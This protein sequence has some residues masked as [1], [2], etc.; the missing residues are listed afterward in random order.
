MKIL[1]LI[2]INILISVILFRCI[3]WP[4]Y[5]FGLS[6]IEL[7]VYYAIIFIS[8]LLQFIYALRMKSMKLFTPSIII[9]IIWLLLLIGNFVNLER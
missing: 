8:I 2:L 7:I 9:I 6:L 1:I 5:Y 4:N 3:I